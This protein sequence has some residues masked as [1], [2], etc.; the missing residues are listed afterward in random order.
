MLSF[1]VL[2]HSGCRFEFIITTCKKVFDFYRQGEFVCAAHLK[3]RQD[4][5]FFLKQLKNHPKYVVVQS[6]Y[7]EKQQKTRVK[8]TNTNF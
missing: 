3:M 4:V 7:K 5:E 1:C 6:I 8:V 2:F